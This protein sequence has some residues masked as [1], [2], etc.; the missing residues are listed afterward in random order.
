MLL[1][2]IIPSSPRINRLRHTQDHPQQ[3]DRIQDR[4][5]FERPRP[6]S[7]RDDI[8]SDETPPEGARVGQQRPHAH[9]LAPFMLE[10]DV[11]D[12]G[13][14]DGDGRS[15]SEAVDC[16]VLFSWK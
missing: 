13:C 15:C 7:I 9:G 1:L 6:A 8:A 12:G 5:R 2:L 3:R 16:L 10:E 11:G 4:S 14:A